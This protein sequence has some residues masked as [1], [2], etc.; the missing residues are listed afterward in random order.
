MVSQFISWPEKLTKFRLYTTW[1]G[2]YRIDMPMIQSCLQPHKT[3]L[4]Y[5]R[6]D[7]IPVK[8][9]LDRP[10]GFEATQFSRLKQLHLSRWLWSEHL[11]LEMARAE[12]EL[13]LA[14][15]LRKF[16][17]D[18]STLSGDLPMRY[19]PSFGAKEEEWLKIFAHVVISQ[20]DRCC[21]EE[22]RIQ[23]TLDIG[24]QR[25]QFTPEDIGEKEEYEVY[26]WDRM[27]CVREEVARQSGG[28]VTLT[29]SDPVFSREKWTNYLKWLR[30]KEMGMEARD[31]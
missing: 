19:W 20:R 18:F 2:I 14:P 28:L 22:I 24:E 7:E 6:I 5:I 31:T 21:L 27:H 29:Y 8:Q 30:K 16:V 11:D 12:A 26:P 3:T 10:L 25:I 1:S 9:R 13:L 4:K 17:W 15:K 23:F